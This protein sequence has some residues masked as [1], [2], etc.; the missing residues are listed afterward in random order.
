MRLIALSALSA[1]I[2]VVVIMSCA[3]L[4]SPFINALGLLSLIV[5]AVRWPRLRGAIAGVIIGVLV[6]LMALVSVSSDQ[7]HSSQISV[8]TRLLIKV[9]SV[10]ELDDRRIRFHAKVLACMSCDTRWGPDRIQLS[11]YGYGHT[12]RAGQTWELTAR[13]KPISGLRNPG[14]FDLVQWA[15]SKRL[16]ARGYV[17]DQ[18]APINIQDAHVLDVSA[19]RE[20]WSKAVR[21]QT[22]N[23]PRANLVTALTL[24]IKDQ[25]DTA[26]WTL[27][28][29]TGTAHLLAIS[30]MHISLLAGWG[31]LMGRSAARLLRWMPGSSSTF[32]KFD[33]HLI[34]LLISVLCA[35]TYALI[36]GFEL[37]AQRAVLMLTVWG[38]CSWRSR[39]L[40]PAS[41]LSI[42]LFIVLLHNIMSPLSAGFWLS[43][44]TVGALFY[45]HKG[46]QRTT[47]A[48][49]PTESADYAEVRRARLSRAI[50]QFSAAI[51]THVLLGVLLLPVT[52]WFFHS[53]SL[54]APVANLLA[55]PWVGLVVVPLCFATLLC[56]LLLP[57]LTEW[58]WWL[59]NGS[60]NFLLFMLDGLS[61]Y[62]AAAMSLSLPGPA[63]LMLGVLGLLLAMA[64]QG[65]ALR[66]L[67]VPLLLPALLFNLWRAPL[68]GFEVHVLDVGQG[69]AVL[70][71]TDEHTL[72]FDTGGKL[73]TTVS[74]FEAVV[75]PFLVASGRRSIDTLVVSHGDQDHAFGVQD[76]VRRFPD[77][78]VISSARLPALQHQRVEP[79]EAGQSWLLDN[80]SF[81]F[82]HPGANDSGSDNDRSCVLLIH[83]GNSRALLTG[84]IEQAG[85]RALAR[86]LGPLPV[87]LVI[88]PH[89]GSRTSSS[90]QLLKLIQP[91]HV[92]FAAGNR[93]AYGFPHA[94]V[95]LRYKLLGAT[96][97]ETGK[98]GAVSA[99]FGIHGLLRAPT[100]WWQSHRRFWHG[101]VN[102]ACSE[103][104]QGRS[105][106]LRLLQLAHKGKT[107][108]G[109]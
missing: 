63:A 104:F 55:V 49:L 44:G 65:L 77:V 98:H 9:I 12:L 41:G 35:I 6:L 31:Y 66:W 73:S 62:L 47:S 78:R 82:I 17:R 4:P 33:A 99:A 102:P 94:D 34:G 96:L 70:V 24:G 14:G 67:V 1:L 91:D 3:S 39:S 7:L 83:Q 8:D 71:F 23:A 18:P 13:M 10:P 76:V 19:M 45:L 59:T 72:L 51:R 108:C 25:V 75:M 64:P 105:Y 84:D 90:D 100:T 106:V 40:P 50:V 52:A 22:G 29:D 95:Q 57:S 5:F 80:V 107:L 86:R 53:G 97:Y 26:T 16:H 61:T 43:F 28:R 60:L 89:H 87:D 36:A 11:W 37:P 58:V 15:L 79:C 88:A 46:H 69:L 92:V 109:K 32:S 56:S 27:L 101:I 30:G 20:R 38:L 81:S 93:N 54:V 68:E 74:Q 2:T 103:Q 21:E 48:P 42:A 85:E